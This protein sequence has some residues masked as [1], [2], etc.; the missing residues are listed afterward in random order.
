M[1]AGYFSQDICGLLPLALWSNVAVVSASEGKYVQ[2]VVAGLIVVFQ[3]LPGRA[4]SAGQLRQRRRTKLR[5]PRQK[6]NNFHGVDIA[7]GPQAPSPW[8]SVAVGRQQVPPCP[9]LRLERRLERLHQ[10]SAAN[11]L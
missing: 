6:R 3:P 5:M 2:Q 9:H 7:H 10:V 1:R 8:V 11:V 4:V